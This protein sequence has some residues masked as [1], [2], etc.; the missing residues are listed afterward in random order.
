[1]TTKSRDLTIPDQKRYV[2]SYK[3]S[4]KR[5]NFNGNNYLSIFIN[6]VKQ[7]KAH[8][9]ELDDYFETSK[10][11]GTIALTWFLKSKTIE[12]K[13]EHNELIAI[14]FAAMFLECIIWDYAAVNTSQNF[15]EDSLHNISLLGKWKVIPKLVNN[16]KTINIGSEAI[17]LLKKLQAERHDII[18]SKS[19]AVPDTYD[20]IK[21][22]ERKGRKITIPE[23]E[24]CVKEC[25]EG[26]Q[27]VDTTNY[28]YFEK[29]VWHTV[30]FPTFR[31]SKK[32]TG[33]TLL[34]S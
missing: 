13:M 27:K 22:Q 15:T 1:M 12:R 31:T 33:K 29:E 18:H 6:A 30:K 19:K 23:T 7:Y 17:A 26:L 28:W 21:E 4:M 9:K 34:T 25:I 3:T 24:Q 2:E 14:T 5:M 32:K 16:D 20:K 8:K 10:K 11:N